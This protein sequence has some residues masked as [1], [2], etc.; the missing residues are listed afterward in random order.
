[1]GRTVVCV[2]TALG[3]VAACP[4]AA[5]TVTVAIC[6]IEPKRFDV[7]ANMAK[8]EGYVKQAASQGER[9]NKTIFEH[10]LKSNMLGCFR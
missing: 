10:L 8:I 3:I 5:A 2:L 9:E 6:Q 4:A 1:M 7:P